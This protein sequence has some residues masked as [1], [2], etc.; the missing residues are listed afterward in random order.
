MK[1]IL[2]TILSILA[3]IYIGF[4]TFDIFVSKS[5]MQIDMGWFTAIYN[6]IVR[7]GGLLLILAFALVNFTG[8]PLK[9]VFLVILCIVLVLYI[10]ISVVPDWFFKLFGLGTKTEEM[11]GLLGW[12]I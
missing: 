3:T 2:Y 8:N 4:L 11:I 7:Y 6:I 10:I 12:M 5:T 9:I 1:S